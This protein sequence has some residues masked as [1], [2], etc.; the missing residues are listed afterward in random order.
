[1]IVLERVGMGYGDVPVLE[2]FTLHVDR[3]ERLALLGP[4]GCGKSTVLRL[5]A[6]L[7]VPRKGRVLLRGVTVS[8]EGEVLVPPE[9]RGV[10][11]LFQDL[12]L[13]PHMSVEENVGFALKIAKVPPAERRERV[14]ELL[15]MTGLTGL[16]GRM[17]SQLSG[18]QRQRVALAR[19]LAPR[20]DIL[21]LDEPLSGLDEPLA[22][23][24]GREIVALQERLG[25]TMVH[26]THNRREAQEMATRTVVLK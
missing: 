8:E 6:G 2:D 19:A 23:R 17:P 20:P 3:G 14:A 1:M 24:L 5:V 10:G 15:E 12:A 25:F 4:S 26:V 18:G 16:G 11:M 7:E 9:K 22:E 13:W 21:L